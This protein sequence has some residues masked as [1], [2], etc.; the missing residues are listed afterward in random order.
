MAESRQCHEAGRLVLHCQGQRTTASPAHCRRT[1]TITA[2]PNPQPYQGPIPRADLDPAAVAMGAPSPG[3]GAP[4][5]LLKR[6]GHLSKAAAPRHRRYLM[7]SPP[8]QGVGGRHRHRAGFSPRCLLT[9][10][11]GGGRMERTTVAGGGDLPVQ[12][13]DRATE[14]GGSERRRY[15]RR[16]RNLPRCPVPTS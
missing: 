4:P 10:E 9:A 6:Q 12:P 8:P 1:A 16:T 11:R 2:V 7:P 5:P 13:R 14:S 3:E 15:P